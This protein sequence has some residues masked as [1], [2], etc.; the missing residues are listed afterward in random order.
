MEKDV[1]I[2]VFQLFF[3]D[4][5]L[6]FIQMLFLLES[7]MYSEKCSIAFVCI[8]YWYNSWLVVNILISVEFIPKRAT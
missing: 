3:V 5:D 8:I 7:K 1:G 4:K 6:Q 2:T